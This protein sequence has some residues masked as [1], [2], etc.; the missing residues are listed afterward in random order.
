MTDDELYRLFLAGD[1]SAAD[2]LMRKYTGRLILYLD[3]MVHNIRDAED[4]VIETFAAIMT[5]QPD[6]RE[7]GFQA[8]L[9][10]AAR[11][12]AYR[13]R[14]R[15]RKVNVFS[16]DD[17]AVE[18]LQAVHPED[19]YIRDERRQTVRR[20][21]NRID[22]DCREAL[23]LTFFEGLSYA[24]AAGVMGIDTKKV[25]NLL[26]KGKK[27]MRLELAKEGIIGANG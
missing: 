25:D 17:K 9:Y 24:E 20:C 11:N 5:K 12:R 22:P 10:R 19:E 1:A 15:F 13:F 6:I 16:L 21:M 23:W 8:Y 4:L 27:S 7:G 26:V 2:V 3:A 14:S 18:E